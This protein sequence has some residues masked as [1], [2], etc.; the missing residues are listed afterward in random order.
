[1]HKELRQ[2]L[3]KEYQY[4]AA[5][6]AEAQNLPKK[7]FYFS[8]LFGEAQRALNFEWDRELALIHTVTH[9]AHEQ[10]NGA[11][12]NPG[13]AGLPIDWSTIQEQIPVVTADMAA[14]F[15]KPEGDTDYEELCQILGRIAELT[16][17]VSGNGSYLY[18]KGHI[19]I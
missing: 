7:L 19:K 4:A 10:M 3:A 8:V 9:R 18:E 5:K 13:A 11:M 1:M 15:T 12:Q 17:M 14:Y 6:V 16:Y 2:R